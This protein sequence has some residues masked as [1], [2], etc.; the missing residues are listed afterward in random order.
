MPTL[1]LLVGSVKRIWEDSS[2]MLLTHFSSVHWQGEWR[3]NLHLNKCG[4]RHL[5]GQSTQ[6]WCCGLSVIKGAQP[7]ALQLLRN[8]KSHHAPAFGS[9]ACNCSALQCLMGLVVPQ[10]LGGLSSPWCWGFLQLLIFVGIKNSRMSMCEI[11]WLTFRDQDGII[12]F[13]LENWAKLD[14]NFLP[15][16]ASKQ[17]VYIFIFWGWIP[18]TFV[19]FKPWNIKWIL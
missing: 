15:S 16:S 12:S 17:Q 19:F 9:Y 13:L 14:I 11:I 6:I 7:V 3:L 5:K 2:A 4:G 18:R 1:T 8:Y 10:Q